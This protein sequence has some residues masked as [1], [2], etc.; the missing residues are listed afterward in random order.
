MNQPADDRF[1]FVPPPPLPDGPF[2]EQYFDG[3]ARGEL[4]VQ[5]CENCGFYQHPPRPVCRRCTSLNLGHARLSGRAVVVDLS[6]QFETMDPFADGDLLFQRAVVELIEQ[7][8]L[9]LLTKLVT[10]PNRPASV[11]TLVVADFLSNASGE[12]ALAFRPDRGITT[13][14]GEPRAGE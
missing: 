14:P 1:D 2:S 6:D 7:D 13:D 12:P 10:P 8:G 4:R 11:G 5:R 3:L 9:Q